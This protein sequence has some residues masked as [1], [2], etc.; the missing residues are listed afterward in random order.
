MLSYKEIFIV[1][2]LAHVLSDFYFQNEFMAI[3][4]KTNVKYVWIH[5]IIY[6]IGTWIILN[7]I[8]RNIESKFIWVIILSH[9]VI[10]LSK[11]YLEKRE[12]IKKYQKYIFT[13]D[14]IIHISILIVVAYFMVESG[15]V[16]KYNPMVLN[17]LNTIGISISFLIV[18]FVQILLIHKPTNIFIMNIL[19]PYKPI[20]KE[21]NSEN[22]KKAGRMIG[23]IERIIMLFFLLIRQYSSVGLVLTAKSIARYNKISEDKEFAE[24]YLLGTLLSTICV[25]MISII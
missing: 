12:L 24:Y 11:Y 4:K 13:I 6:G 18:L 23:T 16:Y 8:F 3:K 15:K 22:T 19:Q 10:D 5:S 1:L 14:Q 17:V 9:L 2:L 25:L 7:L 20:A 21:K